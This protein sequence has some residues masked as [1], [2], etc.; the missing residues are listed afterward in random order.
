MPQIIVTRPCKV[1]LLGGEAI[2]QTVAARAARIGWLQPPSGP[3]EGCDE[4]HECD[5]GSSRRPLRSM[6]PN[7][8]DPWV[9]LVQ[10]RQV[11][12]SPAAKARPSGCEPV[13]AS[14]ERGRSRR[15]ES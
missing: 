1:A 11:R 6:W 3:R 7:I 13:R 5:G 9:L 15:Q 12:S 8:A 14:C 2:E 10:L 4:F